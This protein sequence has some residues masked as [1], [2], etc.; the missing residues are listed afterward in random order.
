M[1]IEHSPWPISG[2]GTAVRK[3]DEVSALLEL[4]AHA[5]KYLS[6]KAGRGK[7]TCHAHPHPHIQVCCL[8]TL[9]SLI[10]W[11]FTHTASELK[12]LTAQGYR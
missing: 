3:K 12:S 8:H 10:H 6:P 5:H 1:D 4:A 11:S 2:W 9:F 7:H